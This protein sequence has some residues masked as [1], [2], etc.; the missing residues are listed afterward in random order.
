MTDNLT[1]DDGFEL[2]LPT[3]LEMLS[4]QCHLL[5][6]ELDE[7]NSELR[8]CRERI[9]TLVSMHTLAAS[10]REVLR[11]QVNALEAE[12]KQLRAQSKCQGQYGDYS[13]YPWLSK[14]KP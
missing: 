12:L 10:D 14:E 8:R 3:Q 11:T 1:D 6:S 9:A 7:T 2:G 13:T 5:E 4:H